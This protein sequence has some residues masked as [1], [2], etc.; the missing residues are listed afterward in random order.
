MPG[1]FFPDKVVYVISENVYLELIKIFYQCWWKHCYYM[2][3]WITW[4]FF[5]ILT[6]IDILVKIW[7]KFDLLFNTLTANYEYSRN[8]TDDLPLPVQMQL[9]G[10]LKTFSPFFIVF[11]ESALNFKHFEKKNQPHS[12]SISE[13]IFSQRRVY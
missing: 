7:I 8:N 12:S 1:F 5:R 11:F 9:S 2:E 3:D 4:F 13:V 10:K 6:S